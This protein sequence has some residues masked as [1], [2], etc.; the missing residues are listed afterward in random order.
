MSKQ[1]LIRVLNSAPQSL[2]RCNYFQLH[3]SSFLVI[4]CEFYTHL[5]FV[6]KLKLMLFKSCLSCLSEESTC[7]M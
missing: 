7:F 4:E 3:Q 1:E 6:L 2:F 5:T